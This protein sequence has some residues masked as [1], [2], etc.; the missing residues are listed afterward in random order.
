MECLCKCLLFTERNTTICTSC[1][2]ER[3]TPFR[4]EMGSCSYLQTYAPL[5]YT[6]T[7]LQRFNNMLTM[8]FFPTCTKHDEPIIKYFGTKKFESIKSLLLAL[9]QTPVKNKRYCNL[10]F[11][12]KQFLTR[13]KPPMYN[14]N[15]L[16]SIQG[17]I[18]KDF[19]NIESKYNL[20]SSSSTFFNYAWLLNKLLKKYNLSP[21]CVYLK[22]L[23]NKKKVVQY[24]L[25]FNALMNKT[26]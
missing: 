23:R 21:Y 11:F 12:A 25:R 24:E 17:V 2:V 4:L 20:Y 1:G 14:S 19:L 13:Y 16:I 8:I 26:S 22:K 5:N 18:R 10:H 6:Y 15:A 7:R 9:K 3:P